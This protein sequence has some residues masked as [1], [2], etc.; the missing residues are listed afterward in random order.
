[1]SDP[2]DEPGGSVDVADLFDPVRAIELKRER[3]AQ[4]AAVFSGPPQAEATAEDAEL[5]AFIDAVAAGV[6]ARLTEGDSA[7]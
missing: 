4:L 7:A 5:G 6:A 3:Q 1:M 2:V